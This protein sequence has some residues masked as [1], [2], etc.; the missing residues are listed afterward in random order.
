M[1]SEEVTSKLISLQKQSEEISSR[2]I[3]T[4]AKVLKYTWLGVY[5]NDNNHVVKPEP[6]VLPDGKQSFISKAWGVVK[7]APVPLCQP[8]EEIYVK[9]LSGN[10]GVVAIVNS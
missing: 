4:K 5:V 8:G 7:N 10:T 2:G 9:Y 1:T 6:E 3:Y